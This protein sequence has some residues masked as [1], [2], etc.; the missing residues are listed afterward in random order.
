MH[1]LV[2]SGYGVPGQTGWQLLNSLALDVLIDLA[3]GMIVE[4]ADEK[5]K[6]EFDQ[7]LAR[8]DRARPERDDGPK[9]EVTR[10]DGTVVQISKKR[11]ERLQRNRGGM[12]KFNSIKP[13]QEIDVE[14]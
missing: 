9:V 4:G 10:H 3:Y 13:G 11:L 7:Q 8:Y 6:K 14:R 1:R 5:Q 12:V 2:C